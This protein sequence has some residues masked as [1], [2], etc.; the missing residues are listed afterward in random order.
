MILNFTYNFSDLGNFGL[1]VNVNSAQ[2]TESGET[3]TTDGVY[4]TDY[5]S[6]LTM[7]AAAIVTARLMF[8]TPSVD[9]YIAAGGAGLFLTA[10]ASS[11]ANIKE[12]TDE[13]NHEIR[14]K[15]NGHVEEKQIEYLKDLKKN[16]QD[17]EDIALFKRDAQIAAAIAYGA[18]AIAAGAM[19][20][21]PGVGI[22]TPPCA[23]VVAN[24]T[25]RSIPE[26][27]QNKFYAKSLPNIAPIKRPQGLSAFIKNIFI[28]EAKA[29]VLTSTLGIGGAMIGVLLTLTTETAIFFDS[30]ISTPGQR[31]WLWGALTLIAYSASSSTQAQIDKIR[32]N[33]NRIEAMIQSMKE[34]E[35]SGVV[36]GADNSTETNIHPKGTTV[37]SG[38]GSGS[39]SE[40]KSAKP[41]CIG[42]KGTPGKCPSFGDNF[43][44]LP[45]LGLMPDFVQKEIKGITK[46][47][48]A[49]NRN[50]TSGF[51]GA[52][53]A[54]NGRGKA[55]RDEL[56]K[57]QDIVQKK[58]K[59]NGSKINVGD[60]SKK[61]EKD[62]K[63]IIQKE[64][65]KQKT[66]AQDLM[67][68]LGGAPLP[69]EKTKTVG[70]G[71]ISKYTPPVIVKPSSGM[72][73]DLKNEK[74][75][76]EAPA[77]SGE[78]ANKAASLDDFELKN[79][80]ISTNK[81]TSIFEVIS[82]RYN[83]SYDRLFKKMK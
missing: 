8:C 83:K 21:I 3:L 55:I 50:R 26:I 59:D 76:A 11:F 34:L 66:T 25:P 48:D 14:R 69:K 31:F 40:N 58:L 37:D 30:M 29:D 53:Q 60:E 43:K 47:V 18:A 65:L 10:E 67:A 80:D 6:A 16:Y 15:A 61:I 62:L 33:I 54:F 49:S 7:I 68:S 24:G 38:S 13:R 81:E 32:A 22:V 28:S 70:S 56:K 12:V 75:T 52:L 74:A 72:F 4:D 82:N 51:L 44:D 63:N 36:G 57:Q 19:F 2:A 20:F 78:P 5:L 1:R 46:V 64:L 23:T 39:G 17:A 79:S 35:I 27:N 73:E 42:G 9:T 45:S 71:A 41:P 77:A